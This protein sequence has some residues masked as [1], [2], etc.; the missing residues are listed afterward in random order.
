MYLENKEVGLGIPQRRDRMEAASLT[1]PATKEWRFEWE[2]FQRDGYCSGTYFE[3]EKK[4]KIYFY[5]GGKKVKKG[6]GGGSD[7][8]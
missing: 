6:E 4:K 3:M 2:W 8:D 5:S 7:S 1:A